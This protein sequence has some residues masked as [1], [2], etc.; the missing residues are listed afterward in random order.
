[1]EEN[2]AL[3]MI[4]RWLPVTESY[5]GTRFFVRRAG[6]WVATPLLAVL[7]VIEF[8]DLV[9]AIDSIPAIFA[10]TNDPYIVY[11]SN[12]FAI[13]GLRSMYFLLAGVVDRF[14][15]L[16]FALALV[17]VFIGVKML[18]MDLYK[19]PT[20]LSLAGVALILG[21]GVV[22][23]LVATRRRTQEDRAFTTRASIA[24]YSGKPS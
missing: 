18:V 1:M 19:I 6:R 7:L 22:T 21:T 11:T 23:S 9:F 17:L 10:I 14:T 20:A 16:K 24:K 4:R 8:S 15:Y 2:A 5:E 3:R 12:V 13:L